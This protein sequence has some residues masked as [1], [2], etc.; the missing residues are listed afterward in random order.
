MLSDDTLTAAYGNPDTLS[1]LDSAGRG[2][3]IGG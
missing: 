1:G 2:G 3:V